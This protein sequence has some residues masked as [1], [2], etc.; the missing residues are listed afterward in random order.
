MIGALCEHV[1]QFL[2]GDGESHLG[3]LAG[4][5]LVGHI[6]LPNLVADRVK[7][8]VGEVV[9]LITN[10]HSL[11]VLFNYLLEVLIVDFL[12]KHLAYLLTAVIVGGFA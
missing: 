12:T 11:R 2:V 10:L 3:C 9:A 5:H 4:D 6:L 1:A 8:I 7:L